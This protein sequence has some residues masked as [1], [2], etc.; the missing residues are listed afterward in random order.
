MRH[1]NGRDTEKGN[2]AQSKSLEV[3]QLG[4]V[5]QRKLDCWR[6]R[7][8]LAVLWASSQRELEVAL[9]R[10]SIVAGLEAPSMADASVRGQARGDIGGR[11]CCRRS[12]RA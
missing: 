10:R 4:V 2:T 7:R 3:R 1:R 8:E 5:G 9:G 11:L 6:R 12:A